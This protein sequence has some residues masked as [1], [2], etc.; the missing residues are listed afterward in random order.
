MGGCDSR[1]KLQY[2]IAM[3]RSL[4]LETIALLLCLVGSVFILIRVLAAG[5][6][7][8]RSKASIEQF[9]DIQP[10]RGVK[11]SARACSHY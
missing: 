4:P 11:E 2:G 1:F 7:D 5:T 3:S 8:S 6:P 10:T 9:G